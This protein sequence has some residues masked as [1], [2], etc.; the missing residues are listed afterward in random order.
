MNGDSS[1]NQSKGSTGASCAIEIAIIV[2]TALTIAKDIDKIADPLKELPPITNL[3]EFNQIPE[4]ENIFKP[5]TAFLQRQ[6]FSDLN[7]CTQEKI[8]IYNQYQGEKNIE[9]VKETLNYNK[10]MNLVTLI[11]TAASILLVLIFGCF[12]ACCCIMCLQSMKESGKACCLIIDMLLLVLTS[13]ACAIV[14]LI[15][16]VLAMNKIKNDLPLIPNECIK[17]VTITNIINEFNGFRDGFNGRNIAVVVLTS[18]IMGLFGLL[19]LCVCCA[20]CCG[21][22]NG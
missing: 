12:C 1:N 2:L 18:V 16:S 3:T 8:K 20:C 9:K 14:M 10:T 17:D 13:L 7:R 22:V 5:K 4:T 15:C 19:F 6:D 21:A 11:A